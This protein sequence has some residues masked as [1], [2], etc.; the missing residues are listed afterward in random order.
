MS[1]ARS[2]IFPTF[3]ERITRYSG[4]IFAHKPFSLLLPDLTAV[5]F[6]PLDDAGNA[7][8]K[9]VRSYGAVRHDASVSF[10]GFFLSQ[11]YIYSFVS[12]TATRRNGGGYR[13]SKA[14][15]PQ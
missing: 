5:L 10:L 8:G 2:L 3:C 15:L 7:T 4:D 1:K 14:T 11:L 13:A 9:R 6:F 12:L